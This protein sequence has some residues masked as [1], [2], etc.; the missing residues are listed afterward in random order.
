MATSQLQTV[1]GQP[2]EVVEPPSRW[3]MPDLTALWRFRELL[4]LMTRRDLAV[5]YR[6][7]LVGVAWVV[8]QPVAYAAVF[9]LALTF[10]R[11][12]PPGDVPYPVF[13]LTGL[14]LWLFL[15]SVV[16]RTSTSLLAAAGLISKLHFP[17][18]I[19]PFAAVL[20][21]VVD[22]ALAFGVLVGVMAL[23]GVGLEPEILLT[24]VFV[25]L[26]LG[27]AFGIG[28]WFS[29]VAVRYR[30]VQQLVP[31]ILQVGLFTSP[32]IYSLERIPG[33]AQDLLPFNPVTGVLEGF[34]WAVLPDAAAPG[35]EIVYSAVVGGLL[36]V[37]G[38]VYFRRAQ[39]EFADVI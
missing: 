1:P 8:M 2:A 37:T 5:R 6:Q 13:V 33:T 38:L 23:Y 21:Q 22:F 25:L 14:T 9:S 24:P 19:L 26:G 31:F 35:P 3:G 29:A 16:A 4:W 7:T 20:P 12:S 34:R 15:A 17:R 18:I 27:L 10:L 32:V 36:V 30:D 11:A 39:D 28:L